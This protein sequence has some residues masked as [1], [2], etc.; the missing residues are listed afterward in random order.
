MS[1]SPISNRVSARRPAAVLF[2]LAAACLAVWTGCARVV[3]APGSP[4]DIQVAAV[5]PLRKILPETAVLPACEPRAD[6]ARGEH[7]SFQFAVRS[8]HDLRGLRVEAGEFRAAAGPGHL[9]AA[10]TGYV[11]LMRLGRPTGEPA[12]DRLWSPSGLYPDPILDEP[13]ALVPGGVSS[14]LWVS[15][16]VPKDAAPG[17]YRGVVTV[18]GSAAGRSFRSAR[19][20]EIQVYPPVVDKTRLWVTN[21]FNLEPDTLALMN[22][23]RRVERYSE[24]WWAL[25]RVVAR[26][27]AAYRQNVALISPLRLATYA[28][29]GDRVTV[30]FSRFDRMVGIFKEEGVIGRVEGGHIGGRQ[31]TWL[32]PFVVDVPAPGLGPEDELPRF[33]ISDPRARNF[34]SQF[35]PALAAHLAE[36]GWA[37][38]YLQH[39]A[40]E[41]IP[42]NV[43]SYVEIANFVKSLAPGFKIVEACHS[44]DLQDTVDVWVPE[45]DFLAKDP[46]FYADAVKS[47]DEVWFYTCV[48]PQGEFANRFI[49]Q[50][51][52]KTRLL[53]WLNFKAGIPGYLHWGFNFWSGDPYGEATRVQT[54]G[55]LVLP[56]GD[57]WIAYPAEGRLRS[58]IRLEA[59][60][61][62]IV[63]HELL[64]R[65]AETRP[66][67]AREMARQM[68]YE[69]TLYET[70]LPTFR[71]K[72]R[73]LLEMLSS[74]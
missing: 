43:A 16:P 58:S 5:D 73:A 30:D 28:F 42:E 2:V 13:P 8:L 64:S 49:E 51:L 34:Y 25:V 35:I 41:P 44:H 26:T 52:I 70:D 69:F 50:P 61:D 33:P 54:E 56:G 55:G 48:F 22:G 17:L 68:V 38:I 1:S 39:I 67:E 12:R 57:S 40:D 62:G 31:G 46:A 11:G 37:D 65:L 59:M 20:C 15:V 19:S 63:D 3:T 14:A 72:R 45:L 27:M 7:A 47:G 66:D 4:A 21:W 6:V 32:T 10:S 71:E 23:G 60:R 18:S 74:R 29:D 24:R 53:H 9:P 36:R